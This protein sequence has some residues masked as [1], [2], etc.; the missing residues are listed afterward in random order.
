M[1]NTCERLAWTYCVIHVIMEY[2][3]VP[4]HVCKELMTRIQFWNIL[5]EGMFRVSTLSIHL[6]RI[7]CNGSEYLT[8]LNQETKEENPKNE[9][10]TSSKL[11]IPVECWGPFYTTRKICLSLRKYHTIIGICTSVPYHRRS[12]S[13]RELGANGNIISLVPAQL[14]AT[15]LSISLR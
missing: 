4:V 5:H 15:V 12:E 14:R 9:T 8:P 13:E 11:R 7:D 3:H 1:Y 10:Q 2:C 6:S